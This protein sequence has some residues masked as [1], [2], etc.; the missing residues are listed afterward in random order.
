MKKITFIFIASLFAAV[1]CTSLEPEITDESGNGQVPELR[2]FTISAGIMET[3]TSLAKE[4]NLY[5][6]LWSEGDKIGVVGTDGSIVEATLSGDGGT[7]TGSFIY[8][9]A[10]GFVPE[11]AF[12]PYSSTAKVEGTI[13]TTT[14]PTTQ[15]TNPNSNIDPQ[16]CLMSAKLVDGKLMFS[17]SVSILKLHLTGD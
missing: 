13:L 17:H 8:E 3:K 14:L 11:Y 16:A 15:T 4:G 5:H 2:T 1:A 12:F 6:V 9:A 7:S 10:D